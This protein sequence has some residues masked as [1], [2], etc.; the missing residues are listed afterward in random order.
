MV[1]E[2]LSRLVRSAPEPQ[3]SCAPTRRPL[4]LLVQGRARGWRATIRRLIQ[5][6]LQRVKRL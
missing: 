5:R 1:I 4:A 3:L 2:S 6:L